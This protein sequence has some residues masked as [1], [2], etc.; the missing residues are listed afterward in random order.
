MITRILSRLYDEVGL[1]AVVSS[2]RD[3]KILCLQRVVRFI[4][5]GSMS[6]VLALFL[7]DLNV[8]D[9]RIGLFMTMT[10]LGDVVISLV[11]TLTADAVGRRNMLM[12]G[13]SMMTASGI[14]FAL[15]S[16]YWVL[17]I[18]SVFGV[19]SPR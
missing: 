9:Q 7:S 17:V 18:A 14:V 15:S 5:Y 4:A 10:L 8:T 6:L 19:I 2:T 3:T 16:N 11:L 1:Q 13:A 12:F